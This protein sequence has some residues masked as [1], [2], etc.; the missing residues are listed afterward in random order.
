MH[1]TTEF[2]CESRL[3]LLNCFCF[4]GLKAGDVQKIQKIFGSFFYCSVHLEF[5]YKLF[6]QKKND[7]GSYLMYFQLKILSG[8][9][10]NK[11]DARMGQVSKCHSKTLNFPV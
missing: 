6:Q 2:K 7:F 5:H 3:F 4:V 8:S 11:F 1:G 10:R 9:L